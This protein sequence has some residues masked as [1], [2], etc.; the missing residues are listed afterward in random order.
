MA[1]QTYRIPVGLDATHMDMEISLAGNDGVGLKPLPVK[2]ILMYVAG[3]MAGFYIATRPPVSTGAWW[4]VALFVILWLALT[5]VFAHFDGTKRL[6]IQLIPTLLGYIPKSSR[7]V[8]TRVTSKVNDFYGIVGIEDI[9]QNN[10]IVTYTDG[11]YG[12]WFRVV[13]SASI[14]LFDDDK[15]AILD[16]VDSFYQKIGTDYELIFLT[17]K[18]A[19]KVYR[20]AANL[21]KRVDRL[22]SDD[23]ELLALANE[24][25]QTLKSLSRGDSKAIHQYMVLKAD[26]K[27]ALTHARNVLQAEVENSSRMIKQ[28]TALYYDDVVDVLASIYGS[29]GL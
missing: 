18:S 10:G 1:K 11:T 7:H 4:Q 28:C 16:R 21:Q 13:G 5:V 24:Q 15:N 17:C 23:A 25:F 14:L 9:N 27:E 8:L 26:N 20:Q 19:Q 2:V 6:Q 3:I 29:G 22:D 12:L